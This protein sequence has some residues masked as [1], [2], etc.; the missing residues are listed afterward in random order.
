MRAPK[1]AFP[2]CAPRSTPPQPSLRLNRP[3]QMTSR[4]D[5]PLTSP[6]RALGPLVIVTS[7]IGSTGDVYFNKFDQ[8]CGELRRDRKDRAFRRVLK[9]TIVLAFH[10]WQSRPLT[11]LGV[12]FRADS[13][14]TIG[15]LTRVNSYLANLAV[16]ARV[17]A[18]AAIY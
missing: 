6:S 14:D 4:R 1:T 13:G 7:L 2:R 10:P 5:S 17:R 12:A 8:V 16:G 15:Q 11:T 9:T 3:L 18:H